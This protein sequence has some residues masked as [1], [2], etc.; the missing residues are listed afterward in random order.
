MCTE[1]EVIVSIRHQATN[2]E[3]TADLEAL[4]VCYNDI[5]RSVK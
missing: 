4:A 5:F 1:A 2:G 3:K